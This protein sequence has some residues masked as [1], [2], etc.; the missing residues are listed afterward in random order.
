M[1]NDIIFF[2]LETT[3]VSV[4]KDRIVQ[5]SAIKTDENLKIIEKKKLLI[6]PTIL[7]PKEASDVHGITDSMIQYSPTFKQIS[8]AMLE[9]FNTV[10]IYAGYNI[11]KFDVSLLSEEF[12]REGLE[13]PNK[14]SRFIDS[15]K[16][17]SS[18]EKRDLSSALK[19]YSGKEM[20]GAHDAENDV[21]A[22]ID[23]LEG[24]QFRY[25]INLESCIEESSSKDFVDFDGK[26]ILKDGIVCFNIGDNKGKAVI[27]D[28]K[29]ATWMLG[30]DFSTNTKNIIKSIFG[31]K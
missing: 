4:T 26:L 11:N 20:E 30:K 6:N 27:S 2:D 9:Y 13:W 7:I 28:P 24:Q 15:Y 18:R 23:I 31:W 12:I 22:T 8:K 5:I 14:D 25:S 3:G 10:N 29:F 19:F 21:I 16:I 1:N 17:F